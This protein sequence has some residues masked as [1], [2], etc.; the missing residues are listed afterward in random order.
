MHQVLPLGSTSTLFAATADRRLVRSVK[1][2]IRMAGPKA[3]S[4][5]F[6]STPIGL[7]LGAAE[8]ATAFVFYLVLLRFNLVPRINIPSWMPTAIDPVI[9]LI[10]VAAIAA[11]VRY[12]SQLLPNLAEL[13]FETHVRL[14][15]ADAALNRAGE[16]SFLSVA[17]VSHLSG[18]VTRQ[19]G[20]FQLGLAQS[21][22][23]GAVLALVIGQL[24][25]LSW[26]LTMVS[27]AG[28]V[29]LGLP[30]LYLRPI[31]GRFV[32]GQ[33]VAN[34]AFTYRLIKDVRN[35]L[36]LRICGLHRFEVAQLEQM[37]N[38]AFEYSRNYQ[39]LSA[40]A[41]NLPSL[42]GIVLVLCLLWLNEIF[43]VMSA[44]S[45]VPFVYLLNRAVGNMA[46]LSSSTGLIR[47]NLPAVMEL[48]KHIDTLFPTIHAAT[49]AGTVSPRLTSLEIS[50]LEFGRD[51]PLM[52]PL[53]LAVHS[54]E[55]L[56][57]TG[58]SGRGKTTLLMTLIGMIEPLGGRV[59][60]TNTPL[61]KLDH[62]DL[63]RKIGY[64][65][66]E[67]YLIDAD[68]R[69]NLLFGL[70]RGDVETSEIDRSLQL[71]CAEFVH[72]FDDGLAHMLRENGDGIS[73]G[74]KQRLALARCLLRRPE[75]LLL[76]EA[77]ANIDEETE[78]VLFKR[79]RAAYPDLLIIAVSHRSSL[80]SF[81]TTILDLA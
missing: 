64:A 17:E 11:I 73:A 47:D 42:A 72:E 46:L 45:L 13:A 31:C 43:T 10:V 3:C 70:E 35:A 6:V 33:Y 4:I 29:L 74:Q 16:G 39:L 27:L 63:R 1:A 23:A 78:R 9:L 53:S 28:A 62:I 65:G 49:R 76:D 55:M 48:S 60:W 38:R 67:P 56:L 61:D 40:V 7:L 24:L 59:T 36:F 79:L 25:Y 5:L 80:R 30:L 52:P 21:I 54:G 22:G 51:V 75:V 37:L 71:A 15:V 58:A 20:L 18:T 77:T 32:D 41:A 50:D 14:A 12:S 81:A 19:A 66:P 26:Q 57:V 69:S 44:A 34:Q 68:I 8:V 2:V